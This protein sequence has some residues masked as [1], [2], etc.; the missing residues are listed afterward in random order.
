M[1]ADRPVS[2]TRLGAL[3]ACA[4]S[5]A[6]DRLG[7][8]GVAHGIASLAGPGRRAAG[9]VVAVKV[10]PRRDD[11]PRPHLC[12]E[13]IMASGPGDVIVI[14]NGGRLDVSCWGGLLSLAAA[15]RGVEGVVVHGACRDVAEATELGF[16]VFARAA[17]ATSARGRI[18]EES[19]GQPIV[20]GSVAVRSGD[21]VVADDSGVAFI[22][23]ER[24]DE[25]L[26]LARRIVEKEASMAAA[27][28]AGA[29]IVEVM[30]D[31]NF[32][33]AAALR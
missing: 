26:E 19:T 17:V 16:A 28:R 27:L 8:A 2:D 15:K 1:P 10:A 32:E 4:V 18:V 22:P 33:R 14:D 11:I 6:L 13:A 20:I 12:S 31:S 3:D 30:H 7:V 23:A 29:S 5:D 24:A 25:V 9:R 21:L